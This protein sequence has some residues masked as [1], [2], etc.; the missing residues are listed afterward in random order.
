MPCVYCVGNTKEW[1]LSLESR[2][3]F[4]Y[5][6]N[7]TDLQRFS[8]FQNSFKMTQSFNLETNLMFDPNSR[9]WP[10]DSILTQRFYFCP[11]DSILTQNFNFD[12]NFQFWLKFSILTQ[13]FQLWPKNFNFNS[14][15]TWLSFS[16]LTQAKLQFSLFLQL[17]SSSVISKIELKWVYLVF[18]AS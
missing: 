15:S 6:A 13:S 17:F 10:K 7:F 2:S 9:V 1:K 4:A 18:I 11:K 3:N 14:V 8:Y 5:F 16:I 12:P